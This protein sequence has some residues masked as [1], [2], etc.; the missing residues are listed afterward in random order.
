[1]SGLHWLL[2]APAGL[3]ITSAD[4]AVRARTVDVMRRLVELCA[5]LGGNYLVHG[6]PAQRRLEGDGA[7][8]DA[9]ARGEEAW[10]AIAGDAAKAGVVY[11]IEPLAAPEAD[12]VNTVAEAAAIVR[13]IANPALRTMI[14]TSAA[15][16]V[17]KEPV[18]DVVRR[19]M[20]T[21]LVAHVQF[22]D[23][24]RRGPGE[25]TDKFAP[26]V[27][28][29]ATRA[30]PAGSRWS[31]SS[32][33][34]TGRRPRRAPSATCTASWRRGMNAG[35][36][37]KVK[38]ETVERFERDVKLRLPFRFGVITVT[39][40]TQAVIR[41]RISLADGRNG[42]GVAA[43][44]LAAKWFDKN[45][46]LSDAQNVEQL[47]QALD[48]AVGSLSRAGP[49]H[50]LRPL[51]RDLPRPAR[52]GRRGRHSCRWWR[53][54]ARRC[55]TA[56]SSMRWGGDPR[57]L[58]RRHDPRATS[59]ASRRP[60]L[61]PD[62]AGF[63]LPRFLGGAAPGRDD[64]RAPHGRP[65]RSDRRR[66]SV[67]RPERVDDGL[68]ETLEEVVAPLP[69]AATTSSRSAATSRPTSSG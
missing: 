43:E 1:M 58:V 22:N 47:R 53:A 4:A 36:A 44:T 56:R 9:A 11:C 7:A 3:S 40:A 46:A 37:P 45:P 57:T 12:F 66:R 55:S 23:R 33:S 30:M 38:V 28:A 60:T 13:R 42:V 52:A 15:G 29:S 54:T 64:R 62:L 17:E 69:A 50:A 2:V 24:N 41:V 49:A 31:R 35:E 67:G 34:P 59:P 20:P 51:R 61:T 19:W 68:P 8:A 27:R 6:S 32:T 21:G 18:A 63:D 65:R 5:E 10:A 14:D 48:I 16:I 39:E 26:V 25:G